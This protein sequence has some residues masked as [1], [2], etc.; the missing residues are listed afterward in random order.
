VRPK[1]YAI[2]EIIRDF[3]PAQVYHAT[4]PFVKA[5]AG[6]RSEGNEEKFGIYNYF[7]FHAYLV[8]HKGQLARATLSHIEL[9]T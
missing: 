2:F 3:V 9:L 6:Q 8:L 7:K 1:I 5:N 4:C